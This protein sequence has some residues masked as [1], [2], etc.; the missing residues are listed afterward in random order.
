M[1]L[2]PMRKTP[3]DL[4]DCASENNKGGI[5]RASLD[6]VPLKNLEKYKVTSPLFNITIPKDN[7]FGSPAGTSGVMAD[8][9]WVFL[10]P[11]TRSA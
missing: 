8:G 1:D 4:Y 11:V 6:G 7:V 3:D 2:L 5:M 9:F 10:D